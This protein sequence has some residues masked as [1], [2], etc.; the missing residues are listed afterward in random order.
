MGLSNLAILSDRFPDRDPGRRGKGT[1]AD[2]FRTLAREAA[3]ILISVLWLPA[4]IASMAAIHGASWVFAP[5]AWPSLAAAAAGGVPLMLAWRRLRRRG[6]PGAAW[7][8]FLA[9]APATVATALLAGQL[10]LGPLAVAGYSVLVSLP[11]WL[12]CALLVPAS[13]PRRE[14][15]R[16]VT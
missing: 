9:L 3:A 16:A 8:S 2:G 12:F 7:A 1:A 5:G 13:N 10:M 15:G 14:K 11:A 4:G 6:W